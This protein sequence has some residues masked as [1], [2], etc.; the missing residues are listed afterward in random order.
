MKRVERSWVREERRGE[1]SWEEK[2]DCVLSRWL[3]CSI[4]AL[5]ICNQT[6]SELPPPPFLKTVWMA[7]ETKLAFS[8]APRPLSVFISG[9]CSQTQTIR[10]GTPE[11][12]QKGGQTI[13]FGGGRK[14]GERG[15]WGVGGGE[16]GVDLEKEAGGRL[17][18]RA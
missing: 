16:W 13:K 11:N 6:L 18:Q 1:E 2:W 15:V 3:G 10:R 8:V 14:S 4:L 17:C 7:A 5:L 12:A 9:H